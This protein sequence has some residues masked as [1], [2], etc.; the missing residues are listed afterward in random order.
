MSNKM[1]WR[2]GDTNPVLVPVASSTIIEI[3]DL[4]MLS[5]G[6]ALPASELAD[7]GTEAGN[8]EGFH[9]LF[10][11]VAMQQSRSG[12]TAPIRVATTGV[13]E[14]DCLSASLALGAFI[15]VD[16]EGTGTELTNQVVASVATANLA[17]GRADKATTSESSVLVRIVG[18][19]NLGGPQS[20]I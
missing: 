16:E 18:T 4:V 1:R 5:G 9:D 11:G 13:F 17:I 19:V 8:Q 2:Y 6:A 12:D 10:I 14:F 7:T 15:G 3:G 20:L